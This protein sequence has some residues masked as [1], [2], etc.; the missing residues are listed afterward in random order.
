MGEDRVREAVEACGAVCQKNASETRDGKQKYD[1]LCSIDGTQFSIEVKFDVMAART[2]NLAIEYF[3][4]KQ[5]KPS[6]IHATAS[7]VWA[8]VLK[9]TSGSEVWL[10]RTSTLKAYFSANPGIRDV[11]GAGDNNAAIR[12]YDKS[13]LLG[14]VFSRLDTLSREEGRQLLLGLVS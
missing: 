6:G 14:P 8:V 11:F 1:L 3:N 4:T 2:G 10:V 9:T 13:D 7:S 5:G 12:L